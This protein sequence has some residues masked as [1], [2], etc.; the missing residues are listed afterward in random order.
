MEEKRKTEGNSLSFDLI[1][2]RVLYKAEDDPSTGV[3]RTKEVEL[4]PFSVRVS[5]NSKKE[6]EE[7]GETFVNKVIAFNER[8][9][10]LLEV[11]ETTKEE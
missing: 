9:V 4:T 6:A 8:L 2:K 10:E 5:A 7:I 3:R 11:K 1:F